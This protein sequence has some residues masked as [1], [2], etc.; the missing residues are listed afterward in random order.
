[1]AAL[2][3]RIAVWNTAFLGDSVLTLPL[4]DTLG[5]AFPEAVVDFYVRPGLG[6]L[7]AGQDGIRVTEVPRQDFLTFLRQTVRPRHHDLWLGAHPSPRAALAAL[8]S[9]ARLRVGYSGG[10]RFF[11]YNR[12]VPRRFDELD[13][14]ERLLQLLRPVQ[15]QFPGVLPGDFDPDDAKATDHWPV[16]TLPATAEAKAQAFWDQHALHEKPV[17]GIHPGSVWPT[18]RW[19]GFA[20]VAKQAAQAGCAILVFGGPGEEAMAAD[21][22]RDAELTGALNLGLER[23]EA[24]AEPVAV[25]TVAE[26]VPEVQSAENDPETISTV[27]PEKKT[28]VTVENAE[29]TEASAIA[30]TQDTAG[31]NS[32]AALEIAPAVTPEN[33]DEIV[34]ENSSEATVNVYNL[35]GK[36]SLPELAA[37]LRRLHAYTG[38]D[39]GPMHLAWVQGTPVSAVFGPTVRS[40]GFFPR[41]LNVHNAVVLEIDLPCRPCG[42]HGPKVCPLAHHRC[43][44]GI[45]PARVWK[46][47]RL[48]IFG[49]REF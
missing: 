22:L 29:S 41:A 17:L 4:L 21:M 31:I 2:P 49:K 43:M 33:A 30:A 1:M 11:G 5:V 37:F 10:G 36:L 46:S 35:A 39:S 45:E 6:S 7:F 19:G 44:T 23:A 28:Q 14:I 15:K 20:E 3:L 47:L 9:G 48:Q 24:K 32:E 40:L 12:L 26:T 16:L 42:L 25:E 18:K 8:V 34:P 38:N 27:I 13:E